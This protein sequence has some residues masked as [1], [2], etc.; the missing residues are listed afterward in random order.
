ARD[1]ARPRDAGRGERGRV[2]AAG[3]LVRRAA[4]DLRERARHAAH[5]A[6]AAPVDGVDDQRRAA[7]GHPRH[8]VPRRRDRHRRGAR[9]L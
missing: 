1:D 7:G 4:G 2:G 6:E 8:G 5:R 9:A 3:E